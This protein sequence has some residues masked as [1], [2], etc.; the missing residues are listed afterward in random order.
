MKVFYHDQFTFPLS[1]NHRFPIEKYARLREAIVAEG[2]IPPGNLQVPDAACDEQLSLAHDREYIQ[3][4]V[5]GRLSKDEVRA[6]GLPWSPQLVM[7]IIRSIPRLPVVS[8]LPWM[9]FF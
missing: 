3:K 8:I 1:D 9:F 6:T 4:V 5:E 2:I 7:F